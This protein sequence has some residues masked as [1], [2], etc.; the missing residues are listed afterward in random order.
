MAAS[1]VLTALVV[2]VPFLQSAFSF[3]PITV[4]EYILALVIGALILPISEAVKYFKKKK[5]S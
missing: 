2:F 4:W 5:N 1:F 3:M